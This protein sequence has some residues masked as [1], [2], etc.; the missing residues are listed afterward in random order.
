MTF[1]GAAAD[2]NKTWMLKCPFHLP[3]LGDLQKEFPDSRVVWTHRN[4]VDC[5]GSACSLYETLFHLTIDSWTLDKRKLGAAVLELTKQSLDRALEVCDAGEIK[6]LHLRYQDT[7]G[8]SMGMCA[9]VCEASGLP[10]N[11]EYQK[12][13]SD[14]LAASKA[15]RAKAKKVGK[16]HAYSLADYGLSDELVRKT[17]EAYIRRFDL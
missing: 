12:R 6:I 11:E 10:F 9:K 17:F 5:I 7:T 1:S 13:V 14:Y 15:K 8:D 4:P 2:E 3:Y 16:A